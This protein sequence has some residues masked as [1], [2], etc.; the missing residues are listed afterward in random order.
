LETWK[1]ADGKL[2]IPSAREMDIYY[3][4]HF[5]DADVV[6]PNRLSS[7][8][9]MPT[10]RGLI[11]FPGHVDLWNGTG[12][13]GQSGG[14]VKV[15]ELP[16]LSSA[17]MNILIS[18]IVAI[19]LNMVVISY[20]LASSFSG[21]MQVHTESKRDLSQNHYSVEVEK[22]SIKVVT[23]GEDT[24]NYHGLSVVSQRYSNKSS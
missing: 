7:D 15:W 8:A 16:D 9:L 18:L 22:C 12:C 5:G 13:E 21:N 11:V 1:G 14:N 20:A 23:Y 2:Y 3:S 24:A 6:L 17:D 10:S 19:P 4:T